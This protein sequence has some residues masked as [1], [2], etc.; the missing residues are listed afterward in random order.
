V[1]TIKISRSFRSAACAIVAFVL[2]LGGSNVVSAFT[3]GDRDACWSAWTNAFYYT[4]VGGRG[5][6]RLQE[7]TG[8]TMGFFEYALCIQ[9]VEDATN[10]ASIQ[11]NMI[12]ALCAGFTNVNGKDWSWDPF[13]DDLGWAS[14]AFSRAYQLT[15]NVQWKTLAKNGFD[16]AYNRGFDQRTEGYFNPRIIPSPR[17]LLEIK[18]FS[19]Q[20]I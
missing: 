3:T 10:Y 7:G 4:D 15:G 2:L 20:P 17:L 1:R 19:W 8:A 12:N 16:V 11:T 9:T 18:R 14:I 13:N 6:F 5:Y